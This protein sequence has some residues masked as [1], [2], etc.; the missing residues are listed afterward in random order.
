MAEQK[1]FKDCHRFVPWNTIYELQ[2]FQDQDFWVNSVRTSGSLIIATE[3]DLIQYCSFTPEFLSEAA[4]SE[5]GERIPPH[6][7]SW[8]AC[9]YQV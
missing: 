2:T 6:M 5:G 3:P 7:S 1:H 4:T 8:L 9:N